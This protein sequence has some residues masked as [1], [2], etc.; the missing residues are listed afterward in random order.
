MHFLTMHVR[1]ASIHNALLLH[2]KLGSIHNALL[3]QGPTTNTYALN[4]WVIPYVSCPIRDRFALAPVRLEQG[5]GVS[6]SLS[7]ALDPWL[8]HPR[9]PS[10]EDYVPLT[11]SSIKWVGPLQTWNIVKDDRPT[12][13]LVVKET[14]TNMKLALYV[15]HRHDP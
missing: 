1:L 10:V 12:V 8:I 6:T 14:L 11:T 5:V 2:V 9:P 7:V 3:L 4:L 15:Q 13:K